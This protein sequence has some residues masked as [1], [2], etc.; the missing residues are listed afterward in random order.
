[1]SEKCK[2]WAGILDLLCPSA[3]MEVLPPITSAP[4]TKDAS[5]ALSCWEPLYM[6]AFFVNIFFKGLLFWKNKYTFSSVKVETPP[7]HLSLPFLELPLPCGAQLRSV[8]LCSAEKDFC[9]TGWKSSNYKS[10]LKIAQK[11]L[12]AADGLVMNNYWSEESESWVINAWKGATD[13]FLEESRLFLCLQSIPS[14]F[15][16]LPPYVSFQEK[17]T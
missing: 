6:L 10:D 4:V 17:T 8:H 15:K 7:F 13:T 3:A 12:L 1:M 5:A 9:V 16:Y 2:S 11:H 14:H